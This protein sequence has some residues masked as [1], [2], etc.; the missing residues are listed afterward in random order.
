MCSALKDDF[1]P[2]LNTIVPILLRTASQEIEI[3]G[4]DSIHE[5]LDDMEVSGL[6]SQ[7]MNSRMIWIVKFAQMQWKR[8]LVLVRF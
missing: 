8:R 2:Y 4:N 6:G 1:I 5:F 7:E 3:P